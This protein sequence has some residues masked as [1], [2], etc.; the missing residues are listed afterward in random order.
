M[1][2]VSDVR[3]RD[4]TCARGLT[5]MRGHLAAPSTHVSGSSPPIL[6]HDTQA[7]G[8]QSKLVALDMS[9]DPSYRLLFRFD[10]PTWRH[11]LPSLKPFGLN[12][13]LNA[14]CR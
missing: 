8:A 6:S 12:A 3:A 2:G 4:L 13:L 11:H 9:K 5:V 10:N 1:F 7:Q 14:S